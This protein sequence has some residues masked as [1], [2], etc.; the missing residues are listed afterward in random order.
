MKAKV[1]IAPRRKMSIDAGVS[2]AEE[3]SK[4]TIIVLVILVTMLTVIGSI[5]VMNKLNEVQEYRELPHGSSTQSGRVS[6]AVLDENAG[7]DHAIGQVVLVI[8]EE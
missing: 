7:E 3:V 8:A 2:M 4:R 1:F 6:L 5:S